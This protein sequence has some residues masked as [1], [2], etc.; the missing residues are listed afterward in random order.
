MRIV[1]SHFTKN[2]G[3]TDYFLEYLQTEK[4]TYYCIKHPLPSAKRLTSQ[5]IYFN[6]NEQKLIKSYPALDFSVIGY[7]YNFALTAWLLLLI[8]KKKSTIVYCFGSFNVLPALCIVP[9]KR[10]RIVFWGVDYSPRRFS[11]TILNHLYHLTETLSCHF[12]D[13]LV[14]PNI[15]QQKARASMH[16]LKLSHSVIVPNGVEQYKD[17]TRN[18]A[19]AP[20]AFYYLGSLSTT[21]GVYE[22][23]HE[24]YIKRRS[25]TMLDIFGSGEQEGAIA[26]LIANNKLQSIVKLHGPIE[27][28][29]IVKF[30]Q[31]NQFNLVGI[32]PYKVDKESHI[33][34]GDSLKIK[35]YLA[36]GTP[37]LTHKDMLTSRKIAEHGIKY[38]NFDDL[39]KNV[40]PKLQVIVKNL[41]K[42]LTFMKAYLWSA[43]FSSYLIQEATYFGVK[44]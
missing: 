2:K 41:N 4:L 34:Y 24:V 33:Y 16:G 11:S 20:I 27:H 1:I 39:D 38:A 9:F 40:L 26:E 25:T 28:A 21:H 6:G 36:L 30:V 8:L 15:R 18:L 32:A 42:D 12:A 10:A 5:L 35:E 23:V 7:I 44:K 29:E 31:N 14:Q 17:N 13:L 19:N 22:F 3:T 43:V 37:F